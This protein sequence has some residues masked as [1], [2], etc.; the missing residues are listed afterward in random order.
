MISG[1]KTALSIPGLARGNVEEC[2]NHSAKSASKVG[3][4]KCPG[5]S[6]SARKFRDGLDIPVKQH[7]KS[8]SYPGVTKHSLGFIIAALYTRDT[9]K[10]SV[11]SASIFIQGK[12]RRCSMAVPCK[13]DDYMDNGMDPL[14]F[15]IGLTMGQN[16]N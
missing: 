8:I 10:C 7:I 11:Q 5:S 1:V 3:H 15:L 14:H 16:G 2:A 6:Q 12:A 9:W 13:E 4:F